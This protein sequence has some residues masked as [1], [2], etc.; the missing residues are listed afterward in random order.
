MDV[1]YVR[2]W[3]RNANIAVNAVTSNSIVVSSVP[4]S[5][6]Y[7]DADGDGFGNVSNTLSSCVQPSGYV[8]N[9]QDCNDSNAAIKPTAVEVCNATDDD[10]DGQVNEGVGSTFYIDADG[11][12]YG[13]AAVTSVACFSP[14]GYVSNSNDCNDASG[15]VNPAAVEVCTNS[16]DDNCNG[17]VNEGCCTG[18]QSAPTAINGAYGV[19]RN[20][21]GN[22]FTTPAVSGATSYQW[23]LPTGATG[24]STTNSITL[25]FS[26]TYN[27]GNLSVRAVG[28]CGTSAPFT[29][30][31]VA[32]TAVPAAPTAITGAASN[33][34]AGSTQTYTCTAVAAATSY[35]WTAPTNATIVSGQG[36]QTVTISFAANF[37][38]SGTVSVKSQNCFGLSVARTLTVY[39]IPG[40]PGVISGAVNNVCGGSVLTY[41][42]AAVPG[43]S[44]YSWTA[45]ANT[46]I[47]S[48]QG[49][50]SISLSIGAAF[51]S[52]TLSVRAV[53]S[54]GQSAART[55]ALSKNPATPSAMSGQLSNLCGGGQFTYSVTAVSGAVSYNWVVP[56]GCTIV[57]NS[58]NSIVMNV[59][60][61]FTTGTLSVTAVN[62]C[63]GTSVRSVSLTRLPATPASITGA[64]SVCP[65]QVGVTFTTPAVT[66][67]TQLWTAPTG[68]V[69]TAGQGTT[70]MTCTWGTV[71]GSVTVKSVNACG[72]SAAFSKAVTLL[73]CMQEEEGSAIEERTSD[74]NVYPNPNTGQFTI[75]T[76]TAGEYQLLN[77]LGQVVDSFS[78]GGNQPMSKDVQGLSAGI[79][80]IRSVKDGAME[81]VVVVE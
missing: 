56:A 59:P 32:N 47:V 10:C 75:R 68:A 52:G 77:G 44:S 41:S 80:Y 16:V 43:A 70:S 28:P 78:L 51:A 23:T 26:S 36:T 5:L 72:Q 61:T 42:V 50:N 81:R 39:N 6:W 58:G 65:S 48:G 71:A 17:Q 31:V 46:T 67:V 30:S 2:V 45:P 25:S 13:N 74:L 64:A 22:V 63:G 29:R 69:I 66:G 35:Q 37:G 9:N 57:T 27:T 54:C 55:L 18:G 14:S 4:S 53:S 15:A 19:C 49:T 76:S 11:D 60:S 33:V 40:T 12:G 1:D 8:S 7:Q 79:Y 62:A 34:C 73:A 38:A 20:S 3:Q 24:S 21:T